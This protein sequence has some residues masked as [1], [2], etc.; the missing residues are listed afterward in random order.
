MGVA[1]HANYLVWMEV[2]RVD[3]CRALGFNYSDMEK[4]G[5]LLAVTESHCRYVSPARYD[6]EIS[7]VAS[8]A[9][10]SRRFITFDYEL[11][12]GDRRVAVGQ[13]RHIFLNKDFRPTRLTDRYAKLFG[14]E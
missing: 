13:T 7:I 6:D 11:L 3:L 12:C 9:D 4:E 2:A 1:Y 10:I 5:V 14:L 8:A